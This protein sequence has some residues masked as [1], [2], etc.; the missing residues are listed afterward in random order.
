MNKPAK[1]VLTVLVLLL[2]LFIGISAAVEVA[3]FGPRQCMRTKGKT[4]FFSDSFAA[5]TGRGTL[6]VKSG[7]EDGKHRAGSARVSLNGKHIFGPKE[8]KTKKKYKKKKDLKGKK[9]AEEEKK[10]KKGK[11]PKEKHE[12]SKNQ[13]DFLEASVDLALF[14][15]ISVELSGKPGSYLTIEVI[16]DAAPPTVNLSAAPTTILTGE[17]TTLSWSSI[18]ADSCIIEPGIGPVE[19]SGAIAV[20]PTET[21]TY[22]ITATGPGGSATSAATVTV[23]YPPTVSIT[24]APDSIMFGESTTLT[25]VSTDAYSA[26]IDNGAGSVPV[27]GSKTLSPAVTTTYTITVSGSGGTSTAAVTVVVNIPN[28]T[29]SLSA[30]PATIQASESSVLTWNSTYTDTCIIEPGIGPVAAAGS[31]QVSPLETTI[32]TITATG[33]GGIASASATVSVTDPNAP[34]TVNIAPITASIRPGSSITLSFNSQRA[35]SAFIDNGVGPVPVSGSLTVSPAHTTAYT[36]TVSGPTGS[37]SAKAVIMVTG[38]PEPQPEGSFGEQYNDL[39]PPDATVDAYDPRRFSL[40]TGLVAS[41]DGSPISGVSV[42]VHSHPEYGTALTDAQGRFSIPVEG[43]A[44][45]TVTYQ[46]DGLLQSQR[47]VYVPWNDIAIAETIQMIGEDPAAR[48]VTFDGNPNTL[49]THKIG[50]RC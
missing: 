7:H 44:H 30:D 46:K 43:G 23:I 26:S 21:T 4:D 28:P 12:K 1:I 9:D 13:Y 14:N 24:A 50:G 33:S 47:K 3:V 37:A 8:F 27:S 36:I 6:I 25:W 45:M 22:T 16:E 41:I 40:I 34:P 49:L 18:T 5:V 20:S 35:Q 15:T 38:S 2:G 48:T 11:E 19:V 17:S 42:T 29:V 31:I 39:I 32:Y 10:H